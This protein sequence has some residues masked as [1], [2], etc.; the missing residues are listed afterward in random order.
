MHRSRTVALVLI[1]L[2]AAFA[3]LNQAEADDGGV[4]LPA[5]AGT[6]WRVIA[7]Y[8][9]GSHNQADGGDPHAIDLVRTDAP[10][11]WTPVLA[12]V[13]GIVTWVGNACLAIDDSA[14]YAHLLCHL[15]TAGSL[16][17]GVRVV[18][19]DEVGR[20]YPAGYDANGGVAHIH[21]AIHQSGGNGRLGSTIPFT[22]AYALEGVDLPWYESY[23][24]YVDMEFTST[25]RAD[26]SGEVVRYQLRIGLNLVI[27]RGPDSTIA[28]ALGNIEHFSHAY[29]YNLA[30]ERWDFWSPIAP[31]FLNTLTRLRSDE[32]I[33][34]VVREES[35][36]TQQTQP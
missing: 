18:A 20:V 28:H 16:R 24:L 3:F 30:S 5:P 31:P 14:G 4:P 21:Y 33:N 32:S 1:A 22:G 7:G 26:W 25:N 35:I 34:V 11:D 17:R 29:R 36:W 9:T 27:W 15:E 13:S 23:N 19:G 6:E 10:T 8:N 12:P 2:T